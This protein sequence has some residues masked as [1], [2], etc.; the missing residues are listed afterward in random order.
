[1][2]RLFTICLIVAA[3]ACAFAESRTTT[4]SY[5]AFGNVQTVTDPLERTT[6]TEYDLLGRVT[7]VVDANGNT[8]RFQYDGWGSLTNLVDANGNETAFEY[9]VTGRLTKKTYDDGT[10]HQYFYDG[11]GRLETAIDA[12]N[13]KITY[14]YD[15]LGQLRTNQFYAATNTATPEKTVTYTYDDYGRLLISDLR[16]SSVTNVYTF[17][18]DDTNRTRTVTVDFGSFSK[19]YTYEYDSN[20][21]K[22]AFIRDQLTTSYSYDA[23]GRL[24]S[25]SIPDEGVITYSYN[26]PGQPESVTLP[27]GT[28]KLFGYDD[29]SA[30][31]TNTVRDP[32]ANTV[33]NREYVRNAVQNI[34][35]RNTEHG[36]YIY[37]YDDTDQ[38]TSE[39]FVNQQSA[40]E[41]RQF[42]YD[43]MGNRL[44]ASTNSTVSTYAVNNL[45]QYTSISNSAMPSA[46]CSLLL[47]D[48]N[49]NTTQK[50]SVASGV[51]S[52]V[53]YAYST[54]N[55]LI[56]AQIATNLQ[57]S[58]FTVQVSYSYDP[59]GRRVSKEI[60][61]WDTAQSQWSKVQSLF[62]LYADEGLVGEF[63]SDGDEIRSYVWK[64]DSLWMN[65]PVCMI[66]PPQAPSPKPQAFF[67]L[68]DHLGAPQRMVNGSG[69]LVWSMTSEAF[70]K[71]TVDSG[72]TV[73]NNLRF[74]SQ[75]YDAET[76]LHYN[77]FRYYCP[78]AGRYLRLD[79][80]GTKGGINL[81]EFVGNNGINLYDD[82][83]FKAHGSNSKVT[84]APKS[85]GC[86]PANP[87]WLNWIIPEGFFP[88]LGGYNFGPACDAHD[89]CYGTCGSDKNT[90][91][92][93]FLTDMKSQCDKWVDR[94]YGAGGAFG[95]IGSGLLKESDR[96]VCYLDAGSFH[97]AVSKGGQDAFR[98]AQKEACKCPNP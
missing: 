43:P 97:F 9:D 20:S 90:C 40:I 3:S 93:R 34:T 47:Y 5:D 32:A 7:A 85:N 58:G 64:P 77:Y 10:S 25:I 61:E 67:Y 16:S 36:N 92:S 55:R 37:G 74:S 45:N 88:N 82:Y 27:G 69:A 41:N 4:Y 59:F 31:V 63:D 75:Y 29:Y 38:L 42:Q 80:I 57:V 68:N 39:Q 76:E 73:V 48:L 56:G 50:V 79:P 98:V 54:D 87:K 11:F 66:L 33:M 78:E 13:Q 22:L 44:T 35:G 95:W 49:G 72:S 24:E 94:L 17:A 2:K 86:G 84:Y 6:G 62:F 71:A 46:P 19:S 83:G 70:G 81:Y 18:Y 23:Q 26:A 28:A 65:D 21:R 53:K 89:I 96:R 14:Q 1:M 51:T 30:L 8:N 52:V 60:F 12:K 91:D 15:L